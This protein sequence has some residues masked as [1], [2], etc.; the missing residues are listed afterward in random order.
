MAR[1]QWPRSFAYGP[2]RAPP[3]VA[4]VASD[5]VAAAPVPLSSAPLTSGAPCSAYCSET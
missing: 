3:L 5:F 4:G 1:V 2:T